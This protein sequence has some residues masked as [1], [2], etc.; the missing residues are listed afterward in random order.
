METLY[1][2]PVALSLGSAACPLRKAM[3]GAAQA[4]S[5]PVYCLAQGDVERLSDDALT[6]SVCWFIPQG[7]E[8]SMNRN[9]WL[10]TP[11]FDALRTGLRY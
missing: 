5:F 4:Q 11:P 8:S 9:E 1:P 6:L 2:S 3:A 7:W 10:S